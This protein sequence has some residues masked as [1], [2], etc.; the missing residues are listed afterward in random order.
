[1]LGR[2]T[3]GF[4]ELDSIV[5][6]A[7]VG[8]TLLFEPDYQTSLTITGPNGVGL[9][10]GPGNLVLQA[11]QALGQK[12]KLPAMRI[13]LNKVLPVASGIGGGSADAAAALRG[14]LRAS[15]TRIDKATLQAVARSVGADVPVCLSSQ[16]SRMRGI[17]DEISPFSLA[18][19][20]LV[21][22]NPQVPCA[23]SD[24]FKALGLKT[25][26]SHLSA[27]DPDDPLGWRN[28]LTLAALKVCPT[29]RDVLSALRESSALKNIRMSGSG[30]TCFGEAATLATA[31]AAA[32]AL[33]HRNPN[34]WVRAVR[35]GSGG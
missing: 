18:G 32:S 28:D 11:V 22:V 20:H 34:W 1:V 24:V 4:H 13:T 10:N 12:V 16:P 17:G 29:I 6:F 19:R 27:L 30:A 35:I 23:T 31:E 26:Q 21:L 33:A 9:D 14:S 7:D 2:R 15:T 8:D 5:A 3:D 25:G